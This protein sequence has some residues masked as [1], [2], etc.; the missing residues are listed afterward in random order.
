MST[1]ELGIPFGS[2]CVGKSEVLFVEGKEGGC[3][4]CFV[5]PPAWLSLFVF[6]GRGSALAVAGLSLGSHNT[7]YTKSHLSATSQKQVFT[8]ALQIVAKSVSLPYQIR[9]KVTWQI[10]PWETPL[11]F[12]VYN[13][14]I[15][16]VKS[17]RLRCTRDSQPRTRNSFNY[18]AVQTA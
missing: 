13:S 10:A 15:Y 5:S 11:F 1:F 2:P 17:R 4:F 7:D 16:R 6:R 9:W 8:T 14:R 18:S 12:V 3:K